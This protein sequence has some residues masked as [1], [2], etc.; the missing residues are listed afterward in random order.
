MAI[1]VTNNSIIDIVDPQQFV[2]ICQHAIT[3]TVITIARIPS[4]NVPFKTDCKWKHCF[5][6]I[7]HCSKAF[8]ISFSFLFFHRLCCVVQQKKAISNQFDFEPKWTPPKLCYYD[9]THNSNKITANKND[10]REQKKNKPFK[11]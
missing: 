6:F 8:H 3:Y 1:S 9:G 2:N 5:S 4:T 11:I 7:L 10:G